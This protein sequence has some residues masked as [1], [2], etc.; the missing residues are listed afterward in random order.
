MATLPLLTWVLQ[1]HLTSYPRSLQS[2]PYHDYQPGWTIVGSGLA[3]KD[4]YRRPVSS[5]IPSHMTQIKSR[6][7]GFEPGT[8]QVVLEDG[9]KVSYDFLIVAP[10]LQ[11]S[12]RSLTSKPCGRS[13]NARL[14]QDQGTSRSPR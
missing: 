14:G 8:N 7:S 1:R 9:S 13:T 10:G 11:I 6:A 3:N 5:L 12:K 4:E 2:N